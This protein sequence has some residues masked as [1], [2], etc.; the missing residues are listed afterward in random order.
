MFKATTLMIIIS[1][2]TQSFAQNNSASKVDKKVSEK[3]TAVEARDSDKLDIRKLEQKYWSAKD[4]DFSVV[5][6]RKYSK[7]KRF[8]LNGSAGIPIN[9]PFTTGVLTSL[10][11][12]YFFNERLGLDINSTMAD[13]KNNKATEA[14]KER[15]G[16][17]PDFNVFKSS[18]MLSVTYVPLYAKMSF[19]D[20]S[21]IYF[22]M[23]FSAGL[24]TTNYSIKKSEGDEEKSALSY[25]WSIN[26]QIFFS[27]HFALRVDFINK[28]T[29]E[30]K[31]KYQSG[32]PDRD[33]G[34]KVVNDTSLLFGL[35]YW[36]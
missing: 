32:S 8:Y 31:L 29:N 18:Q 20:T 3:P 2:A 26:Q 34:S 24:G 6:N 11:I 22:D 5:Q 19:L 16:A 21:I 33:Q 4:D 9:D 17:L 15:F 14:F 27:E 12:G 1:F 30:D 35:T 13:L 25:Q 7:A 36:H 23:G 28:Y 10:Q